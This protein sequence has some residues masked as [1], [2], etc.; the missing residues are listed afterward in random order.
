MS[1]VAELVHCVSPSRIVHL[2]L[3][4]STWTLCGWQMG[5]GWSKTA[6]GR[7]Q[8]KCNQCKQMELTRNYL[9]RFEK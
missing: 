4:T 8:V 2:R 6:T 3:A 1:N 9:T 5:R 7:V